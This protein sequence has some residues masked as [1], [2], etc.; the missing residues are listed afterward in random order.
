MNM[1]STLHTKVIILKNKKPLGT[2]LVDFHFVWFLTVFI[3]KA[4]I[5]S[6]FRST[7]KQEMLHG[8]IISLYISSMNT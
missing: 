8:K 4:S 5:L 1:Y 2:S 7:I 6:L 3:T